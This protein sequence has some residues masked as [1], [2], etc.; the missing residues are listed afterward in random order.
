MI[1]TPA[2]GFQLLAGAERYFGKGRSSNFMWVLLVLG[3]MAMPDSA[4]HGH[5]IQ[6]SFGGQFD[7]D[8]ASLILSAR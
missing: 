3:A 6:Y 4:G 1:R 2:G 5:T 8:Q 7:L